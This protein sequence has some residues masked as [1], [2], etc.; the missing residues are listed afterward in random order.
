MARTN[1]ASKASDTNRTGETHDAYATAMAYRENEWAHGLTAL[2][3]NS[4]APGGLVASLDWTQLNR[5]QWSQVERN[6]AFIEDFGLKLKNIAEINQCLVAQMEVESRDILRRMEQRHS[7]LAFW[8]IFCSSP[9]TEAVFKDMGRTASSGE[10]RHDQC[11]AQGCASPPDAKPSVSSRHPDA[12]M[13]IWETCTPASPMSLSA[14]PSKRRGSVVPDSLERPSVLR[15]SPR[16]ARQSASNDESISTIGP[17]R[18]CTSN[19]MWPTVTIPRRGAA[20][21][22]ADQFLLRA[23]AVE[24]DTTFIIFRCGGNLERIAFR[25][26]ASQTLYISDLIDLRAFDGLMHGSLYL[27]IVHDA[28]DR[29]IREVPNK[30]QVQ[31]RPCSRGEQPGRRYK[32]RAATSMEL[33]GALE[34]RKALKN[35]ADT[36]ALALLEMRYDVYNSPVPASFVRSGTKR[37]STYC[38][39][40]YLKLILTSEIASGGTG[41]VHGAQLELLQVDGK[42]LRT[43]V[44]VKLAFEPQEIE[45]MRHEFLIYGHLEEQGVVEGIPCMFGLSED[46]ESGALALVM[47]HVGRSLWDLRLD[48]NSVE[49][50]VASRIRD[51]YLKIIGNIHKAG[52]RHSDLRPENLTLTDD[53][54]VTVIDFDQA[55]I[56]PTSAAKKREML[57][58][59]DMLGGGVLYD[60]R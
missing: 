11:R 20:K 45:G 7:V 18:S 47:S 15:R 48:M 34:V 1:G 3:L 39:N 29:I 17:L 19:E 53:G 43:E 31:G 56:N 9:E 41:V 13:T 42:T 59:V 52:V 60:S 14:T 40:E 8:E 25:H 27:A 46:V 44:V 28:L 49:V 32:T 51:A 58:L 4:R 33:D 37:K 38:P 6:T 16:S 26:R 36:R 2:L 22:L 23:R 24:H 12:K 57:L 55:V 54:Q 10:L 21:S 50:R 35:Y 30:D 5:S